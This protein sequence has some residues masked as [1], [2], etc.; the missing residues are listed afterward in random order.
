MTRER[1]A[2][3]VFFKK[4]I[5]EYLRGDLR[6]LLRKRAPTLGP[7]A[8]CVGAGVDTAGGCVFGFGTGSKQRSVNF[9]RTY[10]SFESEAAAVIYSCVRCG[11]IHEGLSKL[12]VSWFADYQRLGRGMCLYKRDDGGVVVSLVEVSHTY[13]AAIKRLWKQHRSQIAHFP[14]ADVRDQKKVAAL[15]IELP[16]LSSLLNRYSNF[17]DMTRGSHSMQNV[18]EGIR[19]WSN[20]GYARRHSR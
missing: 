10:M 1:P 14:V 4:V 6:W 8:A 19:F 18:F 2:A 15:P 5:L 16:D 3:E 13:L 9:M 12:N 11:Y 20:D 17:L 7:L